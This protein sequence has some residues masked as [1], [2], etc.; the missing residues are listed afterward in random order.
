M[1]F[2]ERFAT[3]HRSG[4]ELGLRL[5]AADDEHQQVLLAR[6]VVGDVHEAAGDAHREGDDVVGTQVGVFHRF[7]LVPL[8]A[9]APGHRDK[10][11][12]GVVVVHQGAFAGLRLAIAEV[13][14]FG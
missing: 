3:L 9:P 1:S 13:E 12:I 10:C 11:F 7:A 6:L 2:C 5:V 4:R 8:A 14:A